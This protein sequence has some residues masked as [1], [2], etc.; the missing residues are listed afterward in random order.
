M[1]LPITRIFA[2]AL[3]RTVQSMVTLFRTAATNS[4]A[5]TSCS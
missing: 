5:M 4:A 3:S 1:A 2:L